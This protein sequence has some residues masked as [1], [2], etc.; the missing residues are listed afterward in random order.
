[1]DLDTI[2]EIVVPRDRARLAEV[3][4]APGTA[5]LAGG[6]FLYSEPQENLERLV[7]IT[8]LGW[9][10][11]TLHDGLEIAATC[12]LSEFAGATPGRE[13]GLSP[14]WFG[15]PATALFAASCRAL[16]A[17]HKIWRSA[18]VG[19]NI[20]LA[21]PAGAVLAALVALDAEALIW[22][23]SGGERRMPLRQFVIGPGRTVLGPGDVLRSVKVNSVILM[24]RT[25]IRKAALAPLGRSGALVMGRRDIDGAVALTVSAATTRPV[26]LDF[27]GVPAPDELDEAVAGIDEELWFDDPHGD[28]EW[29]AHVTGLLALQVC[30]DLT[31]GGRS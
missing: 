17:S 5:I 13:L 20:C 15:L 18:T 23:A 22:P 28:P 25:A 16:L 21:L 8:G 31:R 19:G 26:V 12:T 7:D 14:R 3:G 30:A 1:M 27:Y 11:L 10:A 2:R 9:P 4:S 24:S 29:R 6:T